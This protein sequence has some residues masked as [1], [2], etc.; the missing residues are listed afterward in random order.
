[1]NC[2]RR[3][4]DGDGGSTTGESINRAI[5]GDQSHSIQRRRKDG[6]PYVL[7]QWYIFWILFWF[8]RPQ[9]ATERVMP[10]ITRARK[11]KAT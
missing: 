4:D 9:F 6:I 10:G 8:M 7:E 3:Q 2:D 11:G 5:K 1:M